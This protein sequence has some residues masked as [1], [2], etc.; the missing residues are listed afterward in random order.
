MTTDFKLSL[1][2]NGDA[3]LGLT[4]HS[5]QPGWQVTRLPGANCLDPRNNS[6]FMSHLHII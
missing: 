6:Q 5:G 2:Y 1:L 3:P 4:Q